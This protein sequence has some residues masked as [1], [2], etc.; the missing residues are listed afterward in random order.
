ME[1]QTNL[2]ASWQDVVGE[3]TGK[4]YFQSLQAFLEGERAYRSAR[5]AHALERYEA[6]LAQDSTLAVAALNGAQAATWIERADEADRLARLA[7]VGAG[8]LPAHRAALI[9]AYVYG[10]KAREIAEI[11]GRSVGTV[12]ARLFR[13]RKQLERGLWEYAQAQNLIHG[14]GVAT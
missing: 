6:A 5:F 9:L 14:P 1:T 3:E 7:L 11:T 4:T 13:G 10:Y 2:P 8:A 12:L